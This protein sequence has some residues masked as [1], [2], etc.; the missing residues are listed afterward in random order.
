[1]GRHAGTAVQRDA[2]YQYVNH[3]Q[4]QDAA[5]HRYLGGDVFHVVDVQRWVSLARQRRL[6]L[7][8]DNQLGTTLHSGLRHS[9]QFGNAATPTRIN[10]NWTTLAT[11]P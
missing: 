2:D 6:T 11:A 5:V 7:G 1:M 3:Q 10:L 9:Q 4:V 8:N